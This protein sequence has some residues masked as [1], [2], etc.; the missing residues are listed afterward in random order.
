MVPVSV[1]PVVLRP[2]TPPVCA[3]ATIDPTVTMRVCEALVEP[4]QAND[5]PV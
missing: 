3:P 1:A 4:V 5:W 2:V